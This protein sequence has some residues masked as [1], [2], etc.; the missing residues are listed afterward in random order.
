MN[1]NNHSRFRAKPIRIQEL[2]I[3]DEAKPG[4]VTKTNA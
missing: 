3:R 4:W 2:N 1:V